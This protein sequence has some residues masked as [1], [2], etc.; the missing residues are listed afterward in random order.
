M[1]IEQGVIAGAFLAV[2][3]TLVCVIP[4]LVMGRSENQD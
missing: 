1:F 4:A 2:T 3:C